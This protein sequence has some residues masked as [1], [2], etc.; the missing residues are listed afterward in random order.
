MSSAVRPI[1]R[2]L[3]V[4]GIRRTPTV[5]SHAST[6]A[7][8]TE[9]SAPSLARFSCS[10]LNARLEIS[11]DTVKPTPAQAPAAARIGPLIGE[12]GPRSSGRDASHDPLAT[13][14]GLPTRYPNRI[15]SVI[16]EWTASPS[17]FPVTWMPALASANSGT[18]T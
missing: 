16:G 17:S 12:R 11:S 8:T 9:A 14:S 4:V 5:T 6:G 1:W 10:P 18:I 7:S 15:P 3:S 2:A 13:P